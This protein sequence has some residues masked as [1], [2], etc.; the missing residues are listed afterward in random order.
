MVLGVP[1]GQNHGDLAGHVL[2]GLV[3]HV[4]DQLTLIRSGGHVLA[5]LIDHTQGPLTLFDRPEA[6]CDK[7]IGHPSVGL[8]IF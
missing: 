2:D 5:G 8:G 4:Q 7:L 1:G 3:D 6:G